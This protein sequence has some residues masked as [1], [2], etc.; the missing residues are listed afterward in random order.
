MEDAG[1]GGRDLMRHAHAV[2]ALAKAMFRQ[3][4]TEKYGVEWVRD[5][6]TGAWELAGIP[7]ELVRAMSKRHDQIEKEKE[8]LGLVE[9]TLGQDK[10][11]SASTREA[12]ASGV[13]GELRAEWRRQAEAVK[14]GGVRLDVDAMIAAAFPD[15][16]A[17]GLFA[18]RAPR[19]P[20]PV[21]ELA[22]KVFHTETG[23]TA[24][25]KAFRRA[26]LLAAI[27]EE[28]PGIGSAAELEDYAD[29]LL[30]DGRFAQ[31]MP[32]LGA[33]H[34]SNH[35]RY[36]TPDIYDAEL[37]ILYSARDRLH[38][39]AAVVPA[40]AAEGAVGIFAATHGYPLSEQQRAAVMRFLRDGHGVDALV[41]VAGA[42]KTTLLTAAYDAWKAA[43]YVVVGCS[44]AA[45]AAAN[46]QAGSGIPS[47]TLASWLGRIREGE[48]LAGVDVLVVDEAGMV[49]DRQLAVVMREAVETG[50]KV[51]LVGDGKQLRSPASAAASTRST[52]WSGAWP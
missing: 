48:G 43:D 23:V 36:T 46:L 50:T 45:T 20:M 31:P 12:K 9:A 51:V 41:G 5:K 2:D 26:E 10:T 7:A 38:E 29:Q 42:G 30:A 3:R 21:E 39:G 34:M 17:T 18:H 49:D 24:H 11:V 15:W 4:L 1:A 6:A 47:T 37:T 52:R 25:H 35:Q 28:L 33:S 44:T 16:P 14:V 13:G 40:L 8:R 32:E 19:P 27:A 22:A